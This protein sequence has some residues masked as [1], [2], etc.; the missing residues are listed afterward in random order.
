MDDDTMLTKLRPAETGTCARPQGRAATTG[1]SGGAAWARRAVAELER[2][3]R[4]CRRN[5]LVRQ[6]PLLRR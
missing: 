6:S 4:Q 1:K 5:T 2:E 3:T